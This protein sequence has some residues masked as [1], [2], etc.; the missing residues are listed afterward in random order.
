MFAGTSTGSIIAAALACGKAAG[1]VYELYKEHGTDIFRR[2]GYARVL[3]A[4]LVSLIASRYDSR[5]LRTCL[6]AEFGEMTLGDVHVPLLLP[7]VNIASGSVHVLKSNYDQEF[8]RDTKVLIRD[9]VLASCSAPTYFNP[10]TVGLHPLV[11]GGLWANNPS[12]VA[13]IEARRRLGVALENLRILSIGTGSVRQYYPIVASGWRER[14]ARL[15]GWGLATRWG[16]S[17][18]V[19]LIMN[20]QSD[21]SHNLM[22][23]LLRNNDGSRQWLRINFETERPIPMDRP[24]LLPELERRADSD[25]A[26]SLVDLEEFFAAARD[27]QE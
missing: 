5:S 12:L 13:A 19:D 18:L 9:A 16:G 6:A 21:N 17:K 22:K 3:P 11:D 10:A 7:T 23:L 1:S 2:K 26:T 24:S 20:L 15:L 25:F 8:V 14:C 4:R 27:R